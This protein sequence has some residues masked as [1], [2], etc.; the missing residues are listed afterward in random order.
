MWAASHELTMEEKTAD[1]DTAL[2]LAAQSGFVE[3]VDVL[4][5]HGASPHNTNEK[6]ETALL[7]GKHCFIPTQIFVFYGSESM[8]KQC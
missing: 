4:L 5:Q 8:L 2:I 3:N 6:N 7:M 1:G